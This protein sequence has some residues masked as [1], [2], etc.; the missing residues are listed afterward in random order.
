MKNIHLFLD[1]FVLVVLCSITFTGPARI[2]DV[3]MSHRDVDY[4]DQGCNFLFL[5][6]LLIIL[7]VSV[8]SLFRVLVHACS[9][10]VLTISLRVHRLW[11]SLL[12]ELSSK[13]NETLRKK[14]NPVPFIS[15][16]FIYCFHHRLKKS[17]FILQKNR[18]W[19]IDLTCWR[20]TNH[21]VYDS[22]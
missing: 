11:I 5:V 21:C 3:T 18:F 7:L 16:D 20:S 1:A 6:Y 22:Y 15:V 19:S 9:G 8:V 12:I 10:R 17:N 14:V 4:R 2:C 13:T